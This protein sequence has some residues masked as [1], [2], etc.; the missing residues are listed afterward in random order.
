MYSIAN[1][2][3]SNDLGYKHII[4]YNKMPKPLQGVAT[5]ERS[6]RLE[7]KDFLKKK[8][9]KNNINIHGYLTW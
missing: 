3:Y 2:V 8:T 5:A 9:F 7:I 4:T 1:I 6:K